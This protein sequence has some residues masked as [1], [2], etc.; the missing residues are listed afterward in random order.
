MDPELVFVDLLQEPKNRFSAR[1]AGATNLFV[2]PARQ[3]SWAEE[4]ES[5]ESIPGLHKRLQ[6]WALKVPTKPSP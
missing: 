1:R 2:V 4:I 6:I 5:S 3:A